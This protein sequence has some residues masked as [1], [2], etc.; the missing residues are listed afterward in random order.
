MPHQTLKLIPGVDQN[1]TTTFNE[2]AISQTNL[3]RFVPDRQGV[4]LVQKLGGWTK[5]FANSVGDIVRALWAWEDTNANTYLGLGQ[6]STS[7]NGNGLSVIYNSN[8]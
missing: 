3:I 8:R 4:A 5:F 7:V 6:Q 2:A 1:R